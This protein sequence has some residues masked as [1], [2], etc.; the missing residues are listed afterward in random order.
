M[1]GLV[2]WLSSFGFISPAF[3]FILLLSQRI[4]NDAASLLTR[5]LSRIKIPIHFTLILSFI[6]ILLTVDSAS[7]R[8]TDQRR[9]TGDG[10][11]ALDDRRPMTR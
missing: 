7:R 1:H 3:H 11:C 4:P 5:P 9:T 6:V 2:R 8:S 10:R